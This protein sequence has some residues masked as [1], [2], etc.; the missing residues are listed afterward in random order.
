MRITP[1]K[2]SLDRNARQRALAAAKRYEQS[3]QPLESRKMLAADFVASFVDGAMTFPAASEQSVVVRVDNIGPDQANAK[4]KVRIYASTDD[5]LDASDQLIG[6]GKLNEKL[7]SSGFVMQSFA[8]RLPASLAAGEYRF[9]ATVDEEL[10]VAEENDL[11]NSVV[12]ELVLITPADIDLSG[13]LS[14]SKI[15]T[16]LVSG[17]G[18]KGEFKVTLTGTG[19]AVLSK[20]TKV[21][22]RAFLRPAGATDASQDVAI[23]SAKRQSVKS[24]MSGKSCDVSLNVSIPKDTAIGDYRIVFKIDA[25]GAIAESN[26]AN[27]E[28]AFEQ[29]ISIAPARIDVAIASGSIQ[30]AR[31]GEIRAA[32]S[33]INLG[34]TK[35]SSS[36]Q[37]QIFLVQEGAADV[38]VSQLVTR[39]ISLKANGISETIRLKLTLPGG[40]VVAPG[41]RVVARMMPSAELNDADASNNSFD[42]GE[43]PQ[44]SQV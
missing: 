38:A 40:T 8:V 2:S 14:R 31:N 32:F 41:A 29:T 25:P 3:F 33:F 17:K 10:K 6:S 12:S 37:I 13:S 1:G 23:S 22:V 34:N 36:A 39:K 44:V 35:A 7:S 27:N 18:A 20:E 26:E 11:N 42:L 28:I 19:T 9:I 24:L 5:V 30:S 43:W 15:D 21:E 4:P 16:N